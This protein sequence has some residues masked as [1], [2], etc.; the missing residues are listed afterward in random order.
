MGAR[1]ITL[2]RV[3][4]RLMTFMM[5]LYVSM[6]INISPAQAE[7]MEWIALTDT[8]LEPISLGPHENKIRSALRAK[9]WS[10]A[11][12]L[13]KAKTPP[14]Q[15]LKAWFYVQAEQWEKAIKSLVGLE[16]HSLLDDEVNALLCQAYLKLDQPNLS[17]EAGARVSRIDQALWFET[18]RLRGQALRALKEW[19][20]AIE[21]YGQLGQSPKEFEQGI[22][23]LGLAM[24]ET[25]KGSTKTGLQILKSIDIKYNGLWVASQARR[26]ANRIIQK[27]PKLHKANWHSRSLSDQVQR[28]EA[29]LKRGLHKRILERITVLLK[30]PLS[31]DLRCRA[32]IIKGRAYDKVRKRSQALKTLSKAI[33]LCHPQRHP[34]TPLALYVAG[35]AASLLNQYKEADGFFELLLT[36]YRHRLSDD[37]AVFMVRHATKTY[38]EKKGKNQ[39][40]GKILRTKSLNKK[41][42]LQLKKLSSKSAPEL[43]RIIDILKRLIRLQA[44]G[45]LASEAITFGLIGL[46]RAGRLDL[47]KQV[48]DLSDQLPSTGFRFHD[49]GRSLYWKA[50]LTSLLGDRVNAQELYEQVISNA[51]LSWYALMAYSRLH[52]LSPKRAKKAV[53]SSIKWAPTGLGLPGGEQHRWDWRFRAN[54]PHWALMKRALMWMRLGLMK[55]GRR[56]FRELASYQDRPD[57]QWLSTWALDGYQQYHWSHDI[58]RRKLIEYRHFPPSGFHLKHWSLAYPAP[59]QAEV[60]KAAKDENV[61]AQF[62]WGVMREESGYSARIQ[63]SASAVGLLQLILPTAKMMRL[64]SEPEVTVER[65]GIP[66][67]NIP[68]GARY[69]AWVKRNVNSAWSL[70][71]AGYNAGG[72]ALK[73]WIRARGHL[74]LDMFVETIPYEE[75]RWYNKRVVASWITFRTL[76]G[77]PKDQFIWPYVSQRTLVPEDS[78]PKKKRSSNA[79]RPSKKKKT[80]SKRKRK[81]KRKKK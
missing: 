8:D 18:L 1:L 61:E 26:E 54:D 9:R 34:E 46:L 80:R 74:P 63:S 62:I 12:R 67:V 41:Q 65:L 77:V 15:F 30:E 36:E 45:D 38:L 40:I 25:E 75:A 3:S 16:K 27:N 13:L 31:D 5:F 14:L 78:P 76:Y 44:D 21:V 48:I 53:T 49:A 35:R 20:K 17:N 73:K 64:K 7:E 72:G 55:R 47:A 23:A 37:A 2:R 68:L 66:K 32:L 52:E 50:R 4:L 28:L 42:R 43:D 51:P 59:F 57:L 56:A 29:S 11:A 39:S 58:P 71:P 24:V 70:V 79:K 19:D 33:K 22:S 10:Y 60:L 6:A 69:L 81:V